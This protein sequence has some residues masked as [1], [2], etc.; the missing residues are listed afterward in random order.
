MVFGLANAPFEFGK[1]M[2]KALGNLK[3]EVA[4]VYVDDIII[5]AKD[6]EDMLEKLEKILVAL[7]KA[8]LTLN[9]AKCIFEAEE[10]Q[11]LGHRISAHG[12]L[13]GL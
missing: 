10:V 5:P 8:G 9:P 2:A 11:Y 6:F 4:L 13:P 7:I 12:I 1:L 3:T